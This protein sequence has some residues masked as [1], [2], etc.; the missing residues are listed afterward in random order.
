MIF[1]F[2]NLRSNFISPN[3]RRKQYFSENTG[4]ENTGFGVHEWNKI[5]IFYFFYAF[6]YN[7]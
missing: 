1:D 4:T 7:N 3:E 2:C 6:I 5:Q